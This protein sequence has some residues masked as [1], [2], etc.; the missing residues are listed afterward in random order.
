MPYDGGPDE[1]ED[2]ADE[3]YDEDEVDGDD[4]TITVHVPHE[5]P[6]AAPDQLAID[7]GPAAAPTDWK[8]P[9][10]S[11]LKRSEHQEVD[12]R[13]VLVMSL[14]PPIVIIETWRFLCSRVFR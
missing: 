3:Y 10:L 1:E 5:I 11:L 13:M 6:E 12:Q 9:P 8:L 4:R 14:V 7:L 2:F